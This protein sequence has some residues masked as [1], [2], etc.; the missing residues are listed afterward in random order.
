MST[1]SLTFLNKAPKKDILYTV[2]PNL[3]HDNQHGKGFRDSVLRRVSAHRLMK[4]F[5]SEDEALSYAQ[6]KSSSNSLSGNFPNLKQF[7]RALLKTEED[8]KMCL[9]YLGHG[10]PY[11]V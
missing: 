11:P 10:G 2:E 6:K 1:V 9:S 8:Q 5:E 7:R 3:Y 4:A